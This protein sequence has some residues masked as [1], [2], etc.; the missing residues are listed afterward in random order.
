MRTIKYTTRFKRD[1]RREKS[2]RHGKKL[3]AQRK[4]PMSEN[5]V[6]RARIDERIKTEAAAV[7][8]AMGLTGSTELVGCKNGALAVP[9]KSIKRRRRL[10]HDLAA[11]RLVGHPVAE[12]VDEVAVVGVDH[13]FVG[14][15]PVGAPHDALRRGVD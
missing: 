4:L 9:S 15:R 14:M 7:L 8:E 6:V 1:Y 10:D 2:G 12:G 5:S 3:V 11:H 13:V